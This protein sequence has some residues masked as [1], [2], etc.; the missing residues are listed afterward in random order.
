[1]EKAGIKNNI[2]KNR[3]AVL[4][5]NL[6]S[7]IIYKCGRVVLSRTSVYFSVDTGRKLNVH[8]TFNLRPVSTGF[9]ISKLTMSFSYSFNVPCT[10]LS[11]VYFYTVCSISSFLFH[12]SQLK[13]GVVNQMSHLYF[14]RKATIDQLNVQTVTAEKEKW[15]NLSKVTHV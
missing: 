2:K 1:M 15:Y 14:C 10:I 8:K 13:S 7:A 5:W 4:W 9:A 6:P 12:R 3:H 11:N